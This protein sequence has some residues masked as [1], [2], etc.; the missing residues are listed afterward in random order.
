[1]SL[2]FFTVLMLQKWLITWPMSSLSRIILINSKLLK[3]IRSGPRLVMSS[4]LVGLVNLLK[5]QP[6]VA[7]IEI[8]TQL[9]YLF[10]LD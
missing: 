1:M 8:V 6:P 7:P 2:N 4:F 3:V 10:K 5:Y 9:L